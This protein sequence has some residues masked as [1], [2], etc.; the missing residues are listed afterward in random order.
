MASY[1]AFYGRR[2]QFPVGW[3]EPGDSSLLGTD[4]VHDALEKVKVVEEQLLTTQSRKK[5]YADRKVRMEI[6]AKSY[7]VKV[8]RIIKKG[9]YPLP[10][11]GQPP[12]DPKYIDDYSDEQM[13]VV[14]VNAKAQNLLYNAISGEEYEKISSC[15]TSKEMLDKLEVTY[16]GT[17]KVKETRINLLV[18]DYELFHMNEGESIE[19]KIFARFSKIISD[20]KVFG[21]PYS[22]E[23]LSYDEL[24]GDLIAFEKTHLKKKRQQEK[25]KIVAFKTTT[26][27]SE[28]D[29]DDDAE[30]LKEEIAMV[31][32]NMNGLMR[33]YINKKREGFHLEE[34][35]NTMNKTKMILMK[36][37]QTMTAKKILKIAS[38]HEV[39]QL[40]S[41]KV[42]KINGGNVK[43]GDDSKEKIIGTGTV[44]LSN[45]CDIT[46]ICL[47]DGLN[48]NLL[49][50]SQLCG[51]GYEVKF[52]KAGCAIEDESGKIILLGKSRSFRVYNKCTLS[53]EELVHVIFDDNKTMAEKGIIAG[54]EDIGQEASQTNKS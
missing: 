26:E 18:H 30:A 7:D 37:Y 40:R 27:G 39:K 2:C 43:F 50:I 49:S 46:E 41:N 6:Y 10:A 20:L 44:P 48:Y 42:T 15:D 11:A 52:K 21:R 1:E 17:R 13:V 12:V 25:K 51:S 3:F 33:R 8:W 36:M 45:N 31:S 32:R 47:V 35:D 14:Q 9:N 23:K 5:R 4:L 22:S 53:E 19:E 24:R 16:D 28:N 29:I 38:W 54:N 34:P